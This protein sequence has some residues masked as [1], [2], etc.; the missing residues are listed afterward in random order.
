MTDLREVSVFGCTYHGARPLYSVT[1]VPDNR[2][3]DETEE[4]QPN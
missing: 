4:E 1:Y 2:P 3:T